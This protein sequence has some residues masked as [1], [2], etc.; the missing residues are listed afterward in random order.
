MGGARGEYSAEGASRGAT[1]GPGYVPN[2]LAI[3]TTHAARLIDRLLALIAV[4]ADQHA[5]G[6]QGSGP[7][8]RAHSDANER[9]GLTRTEVGDAGSGGS[10]GVIALNLT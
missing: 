5:V 8:L 2:R 6:P 7:T 3:I 4:E 9:G 1:A 10:A